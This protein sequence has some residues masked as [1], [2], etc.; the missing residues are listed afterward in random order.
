MKKTIALI[1]LLILIGL[2]ADAQYKRKIK[3]PDFFIP[4]DSQLHKQEKLP[5]IKLISK[6]PENESVDGIA[7]KKETTKQEKSV[8]NSLI[9]IRETPS[10]KY[11]YNE[12]LNDIKVFHNT[13]VMPENKELDKDLSEMNSDKPIELLAP[14]PTKIISKEMGEFYN[15]YKK[16]MEN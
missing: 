11:K 14:A 9:E 3:E 12:Y 10:Y 6:E 1:L 15:V 5:Q 2:N 13:G 16:Q 8:T 4:E 7:T